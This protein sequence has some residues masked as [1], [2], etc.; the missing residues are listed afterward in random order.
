M[1]LSDM[2]PPDDTPRRSFRLKSATG[3]GSMS[4]GPLTSLSNFNSFMYA[5]ESPFGGTLSV[6]KHV[7]F[8]DM[9]SGYPGG[10]VRD[11]PSNLMHLDPPMSGRGGILGS[12]G[13]STSMTTDSMRFDFDQAVAEHFPSPRNGELIKGSSPHRWSGGSTT[14]MNSGIFSFPELPYSRTASL[15]CIADAA[16]ITAALEKSASQQRRR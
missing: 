4:M 15:D 8:P 2:G 5:M 1:T 7:M 3:A 11:T 13:L 12:G 10:I 16:A 14:S 6:D 9:V